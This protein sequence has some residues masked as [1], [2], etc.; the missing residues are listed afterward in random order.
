M[1]CDTSN[2]TQQRPKRRARGKRRQTQQEAQRHPLISAQGIGNTPHGRRPQCLEFENDSDSYPRITD[3]IPNLTRHHAVR[4]H[5]QPGTQT[6]QRDRLGG[7]E[8]VQGVDQNSQMPGEV[9]LILL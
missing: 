1:L 8:I 3:L 7:S 9:L 6:Q 5:A 4:S 2:K